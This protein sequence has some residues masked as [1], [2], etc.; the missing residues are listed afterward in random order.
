MKHDAAQALLSSLVEAE[1]FPGIAHDDLDFLTKQGEL[2]VFRAGSQLTRQGDVSRSLHILMD[3]CVRVE[4]FHPDVAEAVELA[5][6]GP[7]EVVV[8]AEVLGG[9]L[10]STSVTAIEDT[11][12][13]ELDV[14]ALAQAVLKY[15]QLLAVLLHALS[16][17]SVRAGER[18]L[19]IDDE[20]AHAHAAAGQ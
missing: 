2:G 1:M 12:T 3:G 8:G 10:A 13:L 18:A 6:L 16:H 14:R 4:R 15:P 20:A 19:T 11:E 17:C 9:R 7:G 5:I